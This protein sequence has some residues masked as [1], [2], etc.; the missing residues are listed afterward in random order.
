MGG[1]RG[2]WGG[3]GCHAVRENLGSGD[4][5]KKRVRKGVASE[6]RERGRG[7]RGRDGFAYI[8]QKKWTSIIDLRPFLGGAKLGCLAKILQSILFWIHARIDIIFPP[9]TRYGV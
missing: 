7:E 8:G 5:K 3:R 6:K 2:G 9:I 1:R 4:E